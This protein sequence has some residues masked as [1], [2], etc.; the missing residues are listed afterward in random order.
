MKSHIWSMAA[1]DLSLGTWTDHFP[2]SWFAASSQAGMMLS[3]GSTKC[4]RGKV[5]AS[6]RVGPEERSNARARAGQVSSDE[7]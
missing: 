3:Y 7:P 4:A 6:S 2:P 5:S 1:F